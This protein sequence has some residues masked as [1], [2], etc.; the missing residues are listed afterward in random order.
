MHANFR[1]ALGLGGAVTIPS[2][3]YGLPVITIASNAFS[4]CDDLTSATIPDSVSSIGD[5]GFSF[6]SD[7]E[8][9]AIPH[10]VTN[11]GRYAFQACSSL[12]AITVDAS[13]L[14]FSSVDGVLFKNAQTTLIQFPGSRAGSYYIRD[15]VT[16][17]GDSAFSYCGR[18]TS[19]TIP[20]SVA[21][22]GNSAFSV[23]S[24]LTNVTIGD[25][26]TSIGNSAFSTCRG[27]ISIEVDPKNWTTG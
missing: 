10:S 15:S 4:Y 22:I 23:C 19:I 1:K 6:C 20:S 2:T 21:I 14:A 5:N 7:L 11:I 25:N 12:T 8:T 13:N 18:V 17:I 3:I 27:L 16:N 24:A 9:V 26:V